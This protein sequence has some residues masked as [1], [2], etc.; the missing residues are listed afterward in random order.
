MFCLLFDLFVSIFSLSLHSL[1]WSCLFS[2]HIYI[3][4]QA[5]ASNKQRHK[6][7]VG[8]LNG[9]KGL[10]DKIEAQLQAMS[11][12]I[13]DEITENRQRE[14]KDAVKGEGEG[15]NENGGGEGGGGEDETAKQ[16]QTRLTSDLE[17]AKRSYRGAHKE[18]KLCKEQIAETQS[19][20]KR[21]V[22]S[23]L[24]AYADYE[25]GLS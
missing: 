13:Q 12:E 10:I 25:K 18:L 15:E 6:E 3:E 9:Q 14:N 17:A 7:I 1:L 21:A 24:S 19:L 16:T 8:L 22:A 23:L 2:P 20:K 4:L 11:T 5:L